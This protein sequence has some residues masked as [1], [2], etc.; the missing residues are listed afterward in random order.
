MRITKHVVERESGTGIR[1]RERYYARRLNSWQALTRRIILPLHMQAEAQV[2]STHVVYST[3]IAE[4]NKL[5]DS[6]RGRAYHV[7]ILLLL[8][9]SV[10]WGI[11]RS[12]D[13]L[14]CVMMPSA[15]FFFFF[16]QKTAYE[17]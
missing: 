4:K 6:S 9:A 10:R 7:Y 5:T 2:A 17:I 13:Q 8:Y 1:V 15:I 11:N 16:K 3:D 12:S 14:N